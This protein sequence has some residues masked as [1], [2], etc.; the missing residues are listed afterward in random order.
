MPDVID[1]HTHFFP[2]KLNRAI[3]K[4]FGE[5]GWPVKY[6]VQADQAARLLK[7]QGV[8]R[9]V[10]LNYS[11]KP[12]MSE[13]LNA[14]THEFAKTHPEAIPFGAIHPEEKDVPGLLDRCFLD[15]GF[16]GIKFHTHVTGIRPDDQRMF[17]VYEKLV[18]HD[19]VLLIHSGTGPSLKG[20]RE[21][22]K[23]VSGAAFTRNVL[24]RF[25]QMKVVVPHLGFDEPDEFFALMGEFPNL[26]MDTTMVL[27]GFFPI[28]IPWDKIEKFSDRILYGSDFP[29]IPYE[30]ETEIR[31]IETSTLSAPAKAGILSGNAR[32]LLELG[33]P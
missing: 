21:T 6:Q 10:V 27:A 11:H 19:R 31:A 7:E 16:K 12:G 15:Y 14:W 30:M 18:E 33:E 5:H 29:N 23:D 28:E 20:Y 24:K 4:W 3:W 17:P 13:S 2:E 22:T 9:Y 8:F 1:F 32:R 26:W 25:P